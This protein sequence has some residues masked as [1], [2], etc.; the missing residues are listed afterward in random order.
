MRSFLLKISISTCLLLAWDESYAHQMDRESKAKT[1]IHIGVY[2]PFSDEHA[3]VGRSILA[4]MELA[5]E[6]THSTDVEYSFDTLDEIADT[7]HAAEV[8]N[9][10]IKTRQ[11]NVLFTGGASNGKVASSLVQKTNILHFNISDEKSI[12]DGKN[13]FLVW[14]PAKKRWRVDTR[15]MNPEFIRQYQEIYMSYP[16]TEAGYSYDVFHILNR[17]ILASLPLSSGFSASKIS[18]QILASTDGKGVMGV[19]HLN[20]NGVLLAQTVGKMRYQSYK[21]A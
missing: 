3:I 12:A 2:A 14:S 10:F 18:N 16:A 19:F 20:P 7:K 1:I 5:Q 6:E 9:Q 21:D 13:S 8:L 4:A 15:K 11:I 17:G